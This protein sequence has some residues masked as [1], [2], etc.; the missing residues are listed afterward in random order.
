VRARLR[1]RSPPV[2][3]AISA[4]RSRIRRQE[5]ARLRELRACGAL[6][7]QLDQP[8][9]VALRLCRV[10]A[11]RGGL[12]GAVVAAEALGLAHVRGL[13]LL[14]P[15]GRAPEGQRRLRRPP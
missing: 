14:Q 9:E 5:R 7:G 2:A 1:R 8:R 12:A 3:T 6:T 15:L 10:A 13:E 4:A 11:L